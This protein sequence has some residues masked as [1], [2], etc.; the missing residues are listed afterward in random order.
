[1]IQITPR[2]RIEE[3]ARAEYQR[4]FKAIGREPAKPVG[5]GPV[6]GLL[7][8][9]LLAYRGRI[10]RSPPTPYADAMR[11]YELADTMSGIARTASTAGEQLRAIAG[12]QREA[13]RLFWRL[14]R[15]ADWRRWIP[16]R[17]L[18]NPFRHASPGEVD[19]LLVFF[20]RR[21]TTS[22]V[23]YRGRVKAAPRSR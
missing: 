23:Q 13:V 4:H 21:Q 2:A 7:E 19:E 12:L 15:P 11:L 3:Y 6:M 14:V 22:S 10:Y 20:Y 16:K 5:F 17:L 9:E 1:M 8:D 18:P